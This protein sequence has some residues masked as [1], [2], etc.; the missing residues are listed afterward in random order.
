[1]CTKSLKIPKGQLEVVNRRMTDNT[2]AKRKK[3]NTDL[4]N[5]TWK[6]TA[7]A[8]WTPLKPG[9]NS[10]APEGLAVPVPEVTPVVL[11]LNDTN[12]IWYGNRVGHQYTSINTNNI[13]KTW[14]SSK[15]VDGV[16]D[17]FYRKI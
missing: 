11:L 15:T 5:I 17:N 6:T 13:N 14:T 1:M 7:R 9:M 2:M 3:T 16:M 4:Q 10:G 12:I 8:T